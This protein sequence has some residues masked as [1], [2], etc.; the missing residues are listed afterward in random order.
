[1][2]YFLFLVYGAFLCWL[3]TRVPF[4]RRSGLSGRM[5]LLLFAAKLLAGVAIGW[6]SLHFYSTG[7]DYWDVNRDAWKEYQ[8]LLTHPGEYFTNLFS[9]GYAKG[10]GGVFDSFQSFW[11]DLRNNLVIKLVSVFN[12]FSRGDYY[13]NS[14]FFNFI[15]F[16][17]HVALYRLFCTLLPGR[18]KWVILG[19]FLL[20]STL[21]FTSGIHKDGI[22]FLLLALI[23]YVVYFALK[24]GKLGLL[25]LIQLLVMAAM[26]FLVRNFVLL[27]LIPALAAWVLAVRSKWPVLYCFL[28]VYLVAG[29]LLFNISA[30]AP[31][32]DPLATVVQKQADFLLL[33]HSATSIPLTPLQPSFKSFVFNMPEALKHLLLRPYL[34]ELPSRILLPMNIELLTYQLL[35]LVFLFFGFRQRLPV[36]EPFYYFVLFFVLTVFLFIG[37]IVPNLGSLVRYRSLYLPLLITPLLGLIDWQKLKNLLKLK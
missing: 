30:V 11:N 24:K 37:Y 33:P 27:V 17:G 10:Y 31:G 1:M 6:L 23:I 29:L 13:I 16:F 34:F 3:V 25:K 21:Y 2:N 12:I 28:G 35:F 20:P 26:L 18:E 7:N 4:M 5:L 22:V 8:L 14:L 19:C 9:S 32:I 15:I 36:R